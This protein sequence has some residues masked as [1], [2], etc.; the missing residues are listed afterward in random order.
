M[1][2]IQDTDTRSYTHLVHAF[3][4]R[5]HFRRDCITITRQ[6]QI[7]RFTKKHNTSIASSS[8]T[9]T[10]S[11][12]SLAL[13]ILRTLDARNWKNIQICRI[14]CY[15]YKRL[16]ESHDQYCASAIYYISAIHKLPVTSL[17]QG[18]DRRRRRQLRCQRSN[19]FFGIGSSVSSFGQNHQHHRTHIRHRHMVIEWLFAATPPAQSMPR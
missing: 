4:V 5:L 11:S 12:L 8:S 1:L 19:W 7:Y 13:T 6:S 14:F 15:S 16:H 18:F 17:A 3:V 2:R 9:T 10:T